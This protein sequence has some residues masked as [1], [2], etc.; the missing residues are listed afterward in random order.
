MEVVEAGKMVEAMQ[1]SA[2]QLLTSRKRIV[3]GH[4]QGLV[5]APSAY[6]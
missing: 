4:V 6:L 3:I 5:G 2:S 1:M